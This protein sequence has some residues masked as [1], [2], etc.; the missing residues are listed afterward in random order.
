MEM[1]LL[2]KQLNRHN[3]KPPKDFSSHLRKFGW[4]RVDHGH[5]VEIEKL[6]KEQPLLVADMLA[7]QIS[8]L[9]DAEKFNQNSILASAYD[10]A[11]DM[12][13]DKGFERHTEWAEP[14]PYEDENIIIIAGSQN[15]D[16]NHRRVD[17]AVEHAVNVLR[18]NRHLTVCFS[19]K[20]PSKRDI[21]S[22][23][24]ASE[25]KEWFEIGLS[26]QRLSAQKGKKLYRGILEDNST[27]TFE[28]VENSLNL[29][30][31]QIAQPCS[32]ALVSSSYHIPR[33]LADF[34]RTIQATYPENQIK[35]LVLIGAEGFIANS[36]K[37][38]SLYF[39]LLI[40]E[41]YRYLIEAGKLSEFIQRQSR[42]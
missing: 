8:G 16:Q 6:L 39:K 3:D 5:I 40:F 20:Y 4:H 37:R 23:Y 27:R 14:I 1:E 9:Y 25:M 21:V 33:I 12:L 29:L 2:I 34:E 24:E 10:C 35:S 31:E 42:L 28:N 38:E 30:R 41:I 7:S 13:R 32:I 18:S 36:G 26:R 15:S 22:V 11:L 17:A 19:G